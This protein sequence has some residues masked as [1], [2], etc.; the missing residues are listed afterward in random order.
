MIEETENV[1]VTYLTHQL[2]L[3]IW[4]L[5]AIYMT[6]IYPN[7]SIDP[8]IY[9]LQLGLVLLSFPFSSPLLF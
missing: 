5:F 8:N 1:D 3:K 7:I 2:L 9:H 6:G 4:L